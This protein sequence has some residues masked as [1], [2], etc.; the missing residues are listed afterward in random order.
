M[1]ETNTIIQSILSKEKRSLIKKVFQTLLIV[2]IIMCCFYLVDFFDRDR[3]LE[4]IPAI[5]TLFK[6]MIP[7]NFNEVKKWMEPLLDTLV[8]S[9]AGTA[10]ALIFIF[11][12]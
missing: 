8:M 12:R 11:F 5:G 3:M 2:G 4:G 6:E 9:I 1:N 7:P 10:L